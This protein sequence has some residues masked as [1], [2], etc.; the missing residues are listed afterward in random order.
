MKVALA[1]Y[2]NRLSVADLHRAARHSLARLSEPAVFLFLTTIVVLFPVI[3]VGCSE[4]SNAEI[5]ETLISVWPTLLNSFASF[6]LAL[7][8]IQCI[9][10]Y[11]ESY[12]A[13]QSLKQSMVELM[14]LVVATGGR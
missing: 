13:C 6:S 5:C 14:K 8:A 3:T 7:Y 1:T 4:S 11:R 10:F 12:H 9:S 2:G